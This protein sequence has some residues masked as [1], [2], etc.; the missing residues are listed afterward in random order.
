MVQRLAGKVGW[1]VLLVASS[2]SLVAMGQSPAL[3]T[4]APKASELRV[5]AERFD[6]GRAAY[7]AQAFAEAA[8]HFEAA[9]RHA[10]S[11]SALGL[12]MRSRE[13]AG[14]LLRAANLA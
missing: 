8:E 11:E 1:V 4:V 6:E 5:A 9:D 3:H 10:P 2:T 12:A 7:K 13:Q 14:Q